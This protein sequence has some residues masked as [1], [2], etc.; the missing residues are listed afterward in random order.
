MKIALWSRREFLGRT[1][2]GALGGFGVRSVL[3]DGAVCPQYVRPPA[4]ST[5]LTRTL[6]K[7]GIVLPVVNMGVMNA[8]IPMLVRRAFESGMRLFDTAAVYERGR[9]EE[10]VGSILQEM[11]VRDRAVIATKIYLPPPQRANPPDR[12]KAYFLTSAEQSLKRL[13]TDRVDILLFHNVSD[14]R[15][16]S[17]PGAVEALQILKKQGRALQ[18]GFSTH[19]NMSE[20]IAA[21]VPLGVYDVILTTFNYSF[22][23][24]KPLFASLE[25]AHAAGI[26]LLAMKTQCNSVDWY[27]PQVSEGLRD[28]YRGP[29]DH[30][31]LLKWVLNHD[32]IAA[33]IPGFTTFAQLDDDALCAHSLEFTPAEKK[34]L[35]DRGVKAA[36]ASACRQCG[37]C[38]ATCPKGA[39]IPELLRI[40]MYAFN[41]GNLLQ[42][43]HTLAAVPAERGLEACR[44]CPTCL[45]ECAREVQVGRR[46]GELKTVFG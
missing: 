37:S 34:F 45:A 44:D 3:G 21:A 36:L 24:D 27:L 8:D 15:D 20:C 1:V 17:N 5:V 4:E 6:G 26:G 29:I 16:L 18:I 7:T 30:G 10:M 31:A 9:N 23:A 41:Y 33:A 43:R 22:H 11:G 32:F 35:D 13:R 38:I 14:P 12:V 40:Q 25:K 46:M 2:A 42:A 19:A 39:D 28:Y